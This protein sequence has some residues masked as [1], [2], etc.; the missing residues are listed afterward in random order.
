MDPVPLGRV[1]I[2]VA[3]IVATGLKL[4]AGGGFNMPGTQMF[5]VSASYLIGAQ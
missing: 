1:E 3:A 5:T 4:R 2:S